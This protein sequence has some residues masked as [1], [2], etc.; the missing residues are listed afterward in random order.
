MFG[1]LFLL[2]LPSCSL[3]LV[4]I[5]T[6][7]HKDKVGHLKLGHQP[8]LKSSENKNLSCAYVNESGQLSW[9]SIFIHVRGLGF[10]VPLIPFAVQVVFQ[11][12]LIRKVHLIGTFRT[13]DQTLNFWCS[14]RLIL[15]FGTCIIGT[16]RTCGTVLFQARKQHGTCSVHSS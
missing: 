4:V 13:S 5:P 15:V 14:A 7:K 3:P 8:K 9:E 1:K 12:F 10:G 6:W 11:R 2:Y 16:S